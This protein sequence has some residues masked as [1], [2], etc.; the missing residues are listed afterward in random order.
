MPLLADI[1]C[2]ARGQVARLIDVTIIFRYF[3]AARERSDTRV[4]IDRYAFELM[5]SASA[6]RAMFIRARHHA[7]PRL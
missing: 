4:I 1:S 7:L 6:R 2:H 3:R 5:L